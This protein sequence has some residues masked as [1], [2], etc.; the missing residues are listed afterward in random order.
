MEFI[1]LD[2]EGLVILEERFQDPEVLEWLSGTLPLEQW[3]HY[4]QQSPDYHAWIV[5]EA[6]HPV[7]QIDV[8]IY[9]DGTAAISLLTNPQLR[10]KG[11]GKRMVETLLKRPEISSVQMIKIGIEPDNI[12]S[13][14]CFRKV[15]F[16]EQGLDDEGLVEF[17]YP[18]RSNGV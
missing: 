9:T 11:Y 18:L 17:A 8:E 12:A 4:V 3:F 16:I 6:G 5:Y 14:N 13:L 7:G 1:E 15:G 10:Y 2:Q